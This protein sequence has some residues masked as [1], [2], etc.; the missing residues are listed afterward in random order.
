MVVKILSVPI[1]FMKMLYVLAK[2]MSRNE[3]VFESLY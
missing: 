1:I 2:N 3:F